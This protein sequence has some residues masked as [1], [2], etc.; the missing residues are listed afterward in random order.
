MSSS[1]WTSRTAAR[2][3][4][5]NV[6]SCNKTLQCTVETC[7]DFADGR[8]TLDTNIWMEGGRVLNT[9]FEKEMSAKTVIHRDSALSENS[10][11]A[12]LSQNMVRHM[13]NTSERLPIEERVLVVNKFT[14]IMAN[15][16]YTKDQARK[17]IVSGLRCY[18]AAKKR[19][20]K[21]GIRMHR[22]AKGGAEGRNIRK[23]LA[24]TTW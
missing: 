12:S 13:R 24:K 4:K 9:F 14:Q 18:E 11:M 23:L 1:T 17:V 3:V 22:S 7:E 19:A 8:P 6:N 10:K 16:G 20:E 15:Y 2:A 21:S 5:D